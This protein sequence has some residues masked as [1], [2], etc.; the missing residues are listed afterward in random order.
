M[1]SMV[2][3]TCAH[4]VLIL[5]KAQLAVHVVLATCLMKLM[6]FVDEAYLIETGNRTMAFEKLRSTA[7]A[8]VLG[9]EMSHLGSTYLPMTWLLPSEND[10]KVDSAD[11]DMTEE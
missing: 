9:R 8:D 6:V 10:R 3:L 11:F 4:E 7:E 5:R 1:V 2:A